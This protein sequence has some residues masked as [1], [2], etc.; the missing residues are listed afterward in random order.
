MCRSNPAAAGLAT[1]ACPVGSD[2]TISLRPRSRPEMN[3]GYQRPRIKQ[4]GFELFSNDQSC[5]R[6]DLRIRRL[7][8]VRPRHRVPCRA[9]LMRRGTEAP[10][11]SLS[12]SQPSGMRG[13]PLAVAFHD[14]SAPALHDA[15][16]SAST[17]RKAPRRY[18]A[19][20][21]WRSLF[22]QGQAP[23]FF[24]RL[25]DFLQQR[26]ERIRYCPRCVSRLCRQEY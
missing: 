14:R 19:A 10:R 15:V 6:S 2:E 8:A 5:K 18:L 24:P 11:P 21:F 9:G 26:H 20:A 7:H 25:F 4:W 23:D 16:P 22:L 12:A 3:P 17:T 1:A 13:Q